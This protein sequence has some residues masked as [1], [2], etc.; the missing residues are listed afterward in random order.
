MSLVQEA[1]KTVELHRPAARI[2][3]PEAATWPIDD[4][5]ALFD[6]PFNDLMFKAQQTHRINFPDGDVE[7]AT[8]LSIK[9]GGC[10]EDCGYC[11]QAARYD[12]GVEAKKILDIDTVL[13]AARQAKANGATRFCMGAA[14]RGPK[15]RDMDKVEEM[16]SKVKA[17]GL[18][19]CAT[20]GML[21]EGQADRLKNAGLDFYNHNLDTAPEFYD[22]VISTR[23]YQDRLDTLGRVRE[24]G[25]KVCCGGIVGMG[26]TRL[27][28]AGLIAQLANLNPYPES[29]PVNHLVQVEGTPLFG[30][31]ALDP[32]EFVRTIAVA[33]I[34]MPKARVRLSAGRRQMGEAV[35]AM[36]FLAGANSI[37]YGDKLLT[38]DNPEAED[39]RTLL[40]KLGL[41]TRG[42]MLDSVQKE[43]CGC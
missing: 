26:E 15:D 18:E 13:D 12:T 27:Q 21:E 32:F 41:Q 29:V 20:L 25:L 24:A 8:L 16:V 3:L 30:L 38:T 2:T 6:L 28:R 34:T 17:L 39:D 43:K 33:R 37:F 10:E 1:A 9:T 7:L 35:Q 4:V 5:L 23:E 11:P 22:N 36:C 14:W 31:E 40:G 19:T 42:A